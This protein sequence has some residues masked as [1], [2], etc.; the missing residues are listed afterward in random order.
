[1]TLRNG[2]CNGVCKLTFGMGAGTFRT[3][4]EMIIKSLLQVR[5]HDT[6]H[7]DY[8][9]REHAQGGRG[10]R[11]RCQPLPNRRTPSTILPGDPW[12]N[13]ST[14]ARAVLSDA[15]TVNMA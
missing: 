13:T 12:L 11:H 2:L 1:M 10:Y 3:F 4:R 7:S 15:N 5:T 9:H 6:Y 14:R 8:L